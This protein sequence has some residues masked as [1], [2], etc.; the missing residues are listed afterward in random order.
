M[1]SVKFFYWITHNGSLIIANE[2]GMEI[3]VIGET[4]IDKTVKH[5]GIPAEDLVD[6]T[7]VGL[8]IGLEIAESKWDKFLK[9]SF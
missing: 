3:P 5:L 6:K 2:R 8:P 1:N 7:K 4:Q 9:N